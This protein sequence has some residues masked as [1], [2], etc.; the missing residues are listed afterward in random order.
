MWEEDLDSI[1]HARRVFPRAP[2]GLRTLPSDRVRPL[3]SRRPRRRL[4]AVA[5]VELALAERARRS[6]LRTL[7][8]RAARQRIAPVVRAS[9]EEVLAATVVAARWLPFDAECLTRAA[10]LRAVLRR[11]G[12]TGSMCVGVQQVPFVA[13]AWATVEGSVIGDDEEVDQRLAVLLE[14]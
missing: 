13:H 3:P 8:A 10:A 11:A 2:G 14:I 4:V 9:P 7:L 6:H 12:H 1:P 5:W